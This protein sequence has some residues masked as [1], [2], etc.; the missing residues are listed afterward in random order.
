MLQMSVRQL[1]LASSRMRTAQI[2]QQP[3]GNLNLM[4]EAS[5]P[6]GGWPVC[7]GSTATLKYLICHTKPFRSLGGEP[8]RLHKQ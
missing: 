6:E 5:S 2:Q 7:W 4:S 1:H 3:G 8:A